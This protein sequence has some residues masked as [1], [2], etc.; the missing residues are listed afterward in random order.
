MGFWV[1][2]LRTSDFGFRIFDLVGLK[3]ASPHP[4]QNPSKNEQTRTEPN[5][6]YTEAGR[7]VWIEPHAPFCRCGRRRRG[8]AEMGLGDF[9]FLIFDCRQDTAT[10]ELP[11]RILRSEL[12][13][14][15]PILNCVVSV[16]HRAGR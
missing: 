2:G 12:A 7:A 9:G 10:G 1:F 3:H 16:L 8:G 11:G 14:E 5:A 6:R 13:W 4:R 15:L